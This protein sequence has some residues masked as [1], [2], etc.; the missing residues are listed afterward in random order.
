MMDDLITSALKGD[1][2]SIAKIASDV[3]YFNPSSSDVLIRL[4]KAH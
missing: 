2:R 1:Q 3:E 4:M